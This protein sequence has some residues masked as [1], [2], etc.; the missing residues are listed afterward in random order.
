MVEFNQDENA[1]EHNRTMQCL[2]NFRRNKV[3]GARKNE[4]Q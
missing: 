4:N 2:Q 3:K 1:V